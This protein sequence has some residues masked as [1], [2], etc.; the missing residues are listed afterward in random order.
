MFSEDVAGIGEW[1]ARRAGEGGDVAPAE[2]RTLAGALGE[3]ALQ[4]RAVEAW[5]PEGAEASRAAALRLEEEMAALRGP[6]PLPENVVD[7]DA[8]ARR[9]ARG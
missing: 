7:M 1:L 5:T 6:T 2:A 8:W 9:R 3:I 4:L